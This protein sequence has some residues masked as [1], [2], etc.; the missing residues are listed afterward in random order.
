MVEADFVRFYDRDLTLVVRDDGLRRLM[1][2]IEG[3]PRDACVW[4]EEMSWTNRDEMQA[5]GLE[6]LDLWGRAIFEGLGG[7]VRGESF[8][9]PRPDIEGT[10]KPKKEITTDPAE[11]D[12]FFRKWV[13]G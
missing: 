6:L 13:K 8:R 3:L 10:A 7:K 1:V 4:R 11:I 12:R 5:L 9:I 2:L